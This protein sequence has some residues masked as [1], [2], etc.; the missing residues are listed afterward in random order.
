[1][2]SLESDHIGQVSRE[3]FA[4]VIGAKKVAKMSGFLVAGFSI[5]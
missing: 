3:L 4:V 2:L 5:C 1:M